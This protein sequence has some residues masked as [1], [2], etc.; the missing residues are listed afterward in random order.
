LLVLDL[1]EGGRPMTPAEQA[2]ALATALHSTAPWAEAPY[3]V[4]LAGG[5]LAALDAAGLCIAR[6]QDAADGRFQEAQRLRSALVEVV[7]LHPECPARQYADRVLA[8]HV[9]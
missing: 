9:R 1:P 2:A 5:A 3:F 6:T 7:R 8:E 4:E